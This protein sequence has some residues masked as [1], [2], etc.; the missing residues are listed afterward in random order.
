[1]GRHQEI[2]ESI[3]HE[4]EILSR[5]RTDEAACLERL[6]K[7]RE[8]LAG[9]TPQISPPIVT[10]HEVPASNN[11]KIALFRSLFR[12]REDVFA[13]RWENPRT[14]KSGYAPA[15]TNEWQDGVCEKKGRAKHGGSAVCGTCKAQAFRPVTDDE[16]AR[17]LKGGQTMGVYP[18]LQNDTCWFLA[19]DFDGDQWQRDAAAFSGVCR[20]NGVP[21]LLERSRS[22]NG[23]HAWFFFAV[24]IE[25]ALARGF[26]S[27]LLTRTMF[28]RHE[29]SLRSYDRL[30]PNQ[31]TLPRGGFGNLIAL[32]LQRGPRE[33]GNTVF[34]QDD[35]TPAPDQWASLATLRRLSRSQLEDL[36]K[37]HGET[38]SPAGGRRAKPEGAR[39]KPRSGSADAA[40][41]REIADPSPIP[42]VLSKSVAIPKSSLSSPLVKSLKDLATFGN[43][44]YFQRQR[45]R[46]SVARTPRVIACFGEDDTTLTLPRG[47]LDEA[48]ILLREAGYPV[49]VVDSRNPVTPI[50]LTFSGSLSTA[51]EEAVQG[52]LSHDAGVLV[53]PPGAG[54]TVIGCRLIA[55][56]QASTLVIVH[57]QELLAQ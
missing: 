48:N 43:P 47:C 23:A 57:R 15:C 12:G 31:D 19:V 13:L 39:G 25:A 26:A 33:E 45:M 40:A 35:L 22:G 32:P 38:Q 52:M 2:I 24:P 14:G 42:L 34:L 37:E 28:K 9:L 17:H 54:K 44:E 53:A 21:P 50:S 30:F 11:E 16:V 3:A 4:E 41:P 49:T 5:L 6:R 10:A 8:E 36:V 46:L 18:L 29:I 20:E 27:A 51:Q 1:M 55:E 7:L 56:R